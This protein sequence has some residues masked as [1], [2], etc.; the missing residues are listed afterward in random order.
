MIMEST[1]TGRD[2]SRCNP[3]LLQK[4]IESAIG[5]KPE[6]VTRLRGGKLLLKLNNDRQASKAVKI[7]KIPD[8]IGDIEVKVEE[9][10]TLNTSKGIIRCPDIEFLTEQEILEGLKTQK[11][12]EVTIMKRKINGELKNTRTAILLFKST[13]VPRSV[14]F[15]LYPILVELY[16]PNP[17]RCTTCLK[18]G[19]TKKWCR[20][21]RVCGNCSLPDH[22][23]E[24]SNTK[25]VSCGDNHH[26]LNKNCPVY[27]DEVEIQ[28]IKTINRVTYGEAKR[29][30]RRQC[31]T[32]PR[33]F[34]TETSYAHTA[35]NS[36]HTH[37]INEKEK[38][39]TE[40][41]TSLVKQAT[42][43]NKNETQTLTD[44]TKIN[45]QQQI[46]QQNKNPEEKASLYSNIE[47]EQEKKY[48]GI[49]HS[50]RRV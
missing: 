39:N 17:M 19:H 44:K 2:L 29:I 41:N 20:G 46:K 26:T 11:V 31:P 18:I 28:K 40:I 14:D 30:R 38:N 9:H 43:Q 49:A 33:K 34:T 32:V 8:R 50:L 1:V 16:I 36:K 13:T 10:P 45:K 7:K 23:N 21:E 15:G 5:S 6:E 42:T 4:V 35:S 25:C 27:I 48:S 37:N 12:S 3:F 24:C 22:E 47:Q